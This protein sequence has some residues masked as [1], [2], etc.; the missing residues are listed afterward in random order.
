VAELKTQRT[1]DDVEAF[2]AAIPGE[3]CRADARAVCNLLARVTG[4]A[5]V[6]W[7]RAIV[8]FGRQLIAG[9]SLQSVAITCRRLNRELNHR[10]GRQARISIWQHLPPMAGRASGRA[11]PRSAPS[12]VRLPE[13]GRH[14]KPG[15]AWQRSVN[16]RPP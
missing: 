4:E 1:G 5:A 15:W 16:V 8:G 2:L 10:S 6:M 9:C 12:A 13:P 7:G 14:C 11:I 3:R